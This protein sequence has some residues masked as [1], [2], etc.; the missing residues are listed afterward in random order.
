MKDLSKGILTASEEA[1]NKEMEEKRRVTTEKASGAFGKA[2]VE[3]ARWKAN[4]DAAAEMEYAKIEAEKHLKKKRILIDKPSGETVLNEK[5]EAPKRTIRRWKPPPPDPNAVI[6]SFSCGPKEA[7]KPKPAV[8][9][10]SGKSSKP[11]TPTARRKSLASPVPKDTVAAPTVVPAGAIQNIP[12]SEGAAAT[13]I[14]NQAAGVGTAA[15]P[16]VPSA[17]SPSPS[18]TVPSVTD[19]PKPQNRRY[20]ARRKTQEIVNES[21]VKPKTCRRK[22]KNPRKAKF[23]RTDR[24]ADLLLGYEKNSTFEQLEKLFDQAMRNRRPATKFEKIRRMAPSKIFISELTDIDKIYKSSEI[25][26]I[27]ASVNLVY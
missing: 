26:D 21:V 23:T 11:S 1:K 14:R 6:P 8:V 2:E 22:K 24:D 17:A 12:K 18:T 10:E 16:T 25:R 20:N 5:A 4:R 3:K 9:T 19:S 13:R 7:A 15:P 27:I